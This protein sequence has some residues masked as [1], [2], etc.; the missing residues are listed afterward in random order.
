METTMT[1]ENNLILTRRSEGLEKR[2]VPLSMEFEVVRYNSLFNRILEESKISDYVTKKLEEG[3]SDFE[4][5]TD[6]YKQKLTEDLSKFK[7]A[8]ITAKPKI[9]IKIEL[10]K[11]ENS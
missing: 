5:Y 7:G 3:I 10:E 9:T 1:V 4:G 6:T 8:L 11:Y 2:V